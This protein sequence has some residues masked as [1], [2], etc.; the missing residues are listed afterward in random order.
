MIDGDFLFKLLVPV[1][2]GLFALVFAGLYFYEK[3]LEFMGWLALGYFSGVAASLLDMGAPY[4]AIPVFDKI[5]IA[6][7]FYW[8]IGIFVT[9]AMAS[10]YRRPVPWKIIAGGSLLASAGQVY[11]GYYGYNFVVQES[12]TNFWAAFFLGVAAY[13]VRKAATRSIDHLVWILFIVIGA[14]NLLRVAGLILLTAGNDDVGVA[15]IHNAVQLFVGAI[16]ANAGALTLLVLGAFDI[17]RIYREESVTDPLTKLPNRRGLKARLEQMAEENGG[18]EGIGIILCDIDHF[19]AV[20][21]RYGHHAG[22]II[23]KKTG[24][25]LAEQARPFGFAARL[26]GEEFAIIVRA[27]ATNA[28]EV[29]AENICMAMRHIAHA[30]TGKPIKITASFGVTI[31]AEGESFQQACARADKALYVAKHGGRNQVVNLLPDPTKQK[32]WDCRQ[33]A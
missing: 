14:S 10:R 3:R 9:L 2:L 19:K 33:S 13:T 32:D 8:S 24:G 4:S 7:F 27:D 5:D 17:V 29:L 25:F 20:N 6:N 30:Y 21:D 15:D 11:F 23:L 22:D 18:L 12:L 16:A 28:L 1:N 31:I 26:G